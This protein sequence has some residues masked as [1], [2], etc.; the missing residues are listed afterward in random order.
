MAGSAWTNQLLN[1]LILSAANSGFSGFFAYSPAPGHGHLIVSATAASG[2]DPF[3]NSY[4][5]G[6]AAY[7]S[8]GDYAQ[9]F[10]AAL[11]FF[12][13]GMF[14]AAGLFVPGAGEIQLDSGLQTN[15][16]IQATILLLSQN[17]GG[18]VSAITLNAGNVT[19]TGNLTV[20]G[21]FT[22]SGQTGPCNGTLF[23]LTTSG[24]S[25]GTAHTHTL[26]FQNPTAT[27]THQL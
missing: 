25:A 3:G 21:T 27:H 23:G 10:S 20:N 11:N 17:A 7:D 14:Q 2:T 4:V 18:G 9:L 26:P 15:T 12:I 24:A 16:D 22:N 19:V 6:V 13:V 1:L 8:S 5:G